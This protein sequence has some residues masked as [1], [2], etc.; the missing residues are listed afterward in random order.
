MS[1]SYRSIGLALLC[2]GTCFIFFNPLNLTNEVLPY[3][4]LSIFFVPL[5]I[6]DYL[7]SVL[8]LIAAV[9]W[10]LYYP[11]FRIFID[12]I[13]VI[14]TIFAFRFFDDLDDEERRVFLNFLKYFIF[15]NTVI[16]IA[17][18]NSD[19]LQNLTYLFF[20]GRELSAGVTML[21]RGV[22]GLSPEP[23]YGSA[24]IIGLALI[25]SAFY[26][27]TF[28]FLIAVTITIYLQASISGLAFFSLYLSFILVRYFKDFTQ[29]IS[30]RNLA[31]LYTSILVLAIIY[32]IQLDF[33]VVIQNIARLVNFIIFISDEGSI[34]DAEEQTG[35]V[36]LILIYLSFTELFHTDY[37]AGFS[38]FGYLNR[39][40]A[41]PLITLIILIYLIS[42]NKLSI[43][44]LITLVFAFLAGPILIW[45]LYY[46]TFYGLPK[47]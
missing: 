10:S 43:S 5:K 15:F 38:Y 3:Y 11:S 9:I 14:A 19:Y 7:L 13:M 42:I 16:C 32:L 30:L 45:P 4:L 46:L 23:A 36:R 26:R 34:L 8:L 12:P 37:V 41:T 22:T 35:S 18:R 27:P 17:Q 21:D 33:S 40:F 6:K 2:I 39:I 47:K 25:Y 20:S 31:V 44:Y 24:M 29:G 1:I 28:I